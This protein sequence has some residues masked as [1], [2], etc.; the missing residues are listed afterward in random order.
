[1][2]LIPSAGIEWDRVHYQVVVRSLLV[3]W[4]SVPLLHLGRLGLGKCDPKE[5]DR[6]R[7][8]GQFSCSRVGGRTCTRYLPARRE[9]ASLV[10]T[11]RKSGAS[12]PSWRSP[13]SPPAPMQRACQIWSIKCAGVGSVFFALK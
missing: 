6:V 11:G 9:M 1:M 13:T 4:F 8:R 5:H 10:S 3:S 12:V 7:R 2:W